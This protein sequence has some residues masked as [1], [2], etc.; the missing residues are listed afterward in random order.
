M[1][2][3]ET[4]EV[5]AFLINILSDMIEAKENDGEISTVEWARIA[6]SNAPAAFAALAGIDSMDD[7]IKDAD[8]A[9]LQELAIMGVDLAKKLSELILHAEV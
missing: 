2:L 3:K 1:D 6:F 7:E 9:E 4:K 8:G 5:H